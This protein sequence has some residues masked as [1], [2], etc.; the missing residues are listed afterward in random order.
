MHTC[1]CAHVRVYSVESLSS[2]TSSWT[3]RP[4]TV[5]VFHPLEARHGSAHTPRRAWVSGGHVR[6]CPPQGPSPGLKPIGATA[7]PVPHPEGAE[8]RALAPRLPHAQS[9]LTLAFSDSVH[10]YRVPPTCQTGLMGTGVAPPTGVSV[11][12]AHGAAHFLTVT[13][14]CRENVFSLFPVT[15][16]R[17]LTN[18]SLGNKEK[19]Q[20]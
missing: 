19:H 4:T 2:I 7:K 15:D 11:L 10:I 13:R 17:C 1:V 5:A 16:L 6:S 8:R 18:P 12:V 3:R 20:I 14:V 9:G